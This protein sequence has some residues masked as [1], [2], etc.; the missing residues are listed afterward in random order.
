MT[1][2][3]NDGLWLSPSSADGCHR[4]R[5][6]TSLEPYDLPLDRQW[7]PGIGTAIHRWLE[8]PDDPTDEMRLA[9]TLKVD[10]ETDDGTTTVPVEL[11][12]TL[13]SYDPDKRRLVDYKTISEFV[14]Y[15]PDT[16]K[17][18]PRRL[19]EPH[20]VLQIN[21]YR[22][23]LEHHN[24]PVD[25]AFIWY[26]KTA[27]D[28]TRKFLPVELWDLQDTL[29]LAHDLAEP[30]ARYRLTGTLPSGIDPASPD[31][32]LC[33]FCPVRDTCFRLRAEGS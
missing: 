28:A 29:I 1:Q 27:K 9:M 18:Q 22:M 7:A 14:R 26:V 8:D 3:R 13:D 21:L 6:L 20:H 15:N 5:I 23:L 33:R 17:R 19:P 24:H 25:E 10:V 30:I 2:T 12:G 32:W 31:A 4:Q 11:K 16:R